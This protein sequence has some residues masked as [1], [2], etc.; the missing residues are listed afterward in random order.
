MVN[1]RRIA[2]M[3]RYLESRQAD[4]RLFLDDVHDP[5]NMSAILRTADAAGL[6][7]IDYARVGDFAVRP[8]KTVVQGSQ[9]WLAIE[10]IPYAERLR[11]LQSFQTGGYQVVATLLD[12][13]AKVYSEIDFTRP[14]IL[15]MGNEKEGVSPEVAALADAT[16]IIPMHGMAQSLNVSVASAVI[17]Y[18]AERQRREA[19]MF[20]RA[21]LSEEEIDRRLKAWC[22]RDGLLRKSRGRV[23]PEKL[24][25]KE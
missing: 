9:R 20:E 15:V 16:I 8:R 17:L 11:H 19:G 7:F 25:P 10:Q 2:R 12:E 13:R 24:I 23:A 5:Y 18:E 6:F 1:D 4:L 21:S 14:T 22:E 3:R